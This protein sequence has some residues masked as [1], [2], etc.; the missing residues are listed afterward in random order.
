MKTIDGFDF[1]GKKAIVRVDFNVP[2]NEQKEITDVLR[3]DAAVPTIE[4]ILKDGGAVILMSHIGRPKKGFDEKYSLKP[5]V[6]YLSSVLGLPVKFAD[7]C[8]SESAKN[9][10]ATLQCGEVLLL[11]NLRFYAEEEGKPRNL[12]EDISDEEKNA[13]KKAMKEQQKIFAQ[14]LASYAEVY[15]NDAF[16]TAHRAHASTALIADYFDAEHKMFGYVMSNEINNIEKV[17]KHAVHPF[18]LIIGGAKVS[19]KIDVFER[20]LNKVD[21]IIVGGGMQ[22]T[23]IKAMGGNIGSSLCETE[24]LDVAKNTIEKAEKAGV[25]ILFAPDAIIADKFD[26]DADRKECDNKNIPDGWMGLDIG[27]QA[28]KDFTE[29]IENAKTILWNGPVG[30]FEMNNF[31]TGTKAIAYAIAHATK[32]GAYSLIGGG[33][34]AAAIGKYGLKDEVSYVSTGGGAMLEY[35]EGK[36]LPGVAAITQS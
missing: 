20:M 13:A 3:I 17:L 28:I 25:K 21:A 31:E 5:V 10:A 27:T 19:D 16:G 8:M 26:N 12:P 24:M 22:Y 11:E 34:S 2:L 7:D 14:H 15:V 6:P 35:I 9:M 36:V 30:V 23:F 32:K 1:R 4:K 33:D 29:V 18:L